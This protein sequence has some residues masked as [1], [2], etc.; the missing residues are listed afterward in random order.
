MLPCATWARAHGTRPTSRAS[1][2]AAI[3]FIK[4]LLLVAGT[5]RRRGRGGSAL[6]RARSNP[7][8]WRRRRA[9]RAEP[10]GCEDGS[11]D[12]SVRWA[13]CWRGSE[14]VTRA[15]SA[16]FTLV[17]AGANG[18]APTDRIRNHRL[19]FPGARVEGGEIGARLRV[20]RLDGGDLL[21]VRPR[22]VGT[23]GLRR[24]HPQRVERGHE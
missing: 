19:R 1:A 4:A 18:C 5:V 16:G 2:S 13:P 9:M 12:A 22:L 23:A 6:R 3:R 8:A 20:A 14:I 10:F 15:D 24:H 7:R 21:P 11:R 17:D